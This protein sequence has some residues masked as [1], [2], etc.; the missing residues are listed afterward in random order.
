[1]I[2]TPAE[3]RKQ[4]PFNNKCVSIKT[5]IR[6]CQKNLLPAGH[7]AKKIPGARGLWI[8]EIQNKVQNN[9]SGYFNM[10]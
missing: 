7:I 2:L 6:R 4:F 3:Y 1:M 8:I 10:R 5:I 9:T